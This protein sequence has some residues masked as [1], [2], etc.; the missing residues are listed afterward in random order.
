MTFFREHCL[1]VRF[2]G[3]GT[4]LHSCN[5][6]APS[7]N[8][9]SILPVNVTF[10]KTKA[11]WPTLKEIYSSLDFEKHPPPHTHTHFITSCIPTPQNLATMT[12]TY[13]GKNPTQFRFRCWTHCLIPY[14]WSLSDFIIV[15]VP[16]HR[17]SPPIKLS[18][19]DLLL[20]GQVLGVGLM[21]LYFNSYICEAPQPLTNYLK[22]NS[23]F[24][25]LTMT[26]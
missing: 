10:H 20:L 15:H 24:N 4:F 5:G 2:W 1:Q 14:A 23:G 26:I 9:C 18:Y 16:P 6:K 21:W 11:L 25:L 19:Y 3:S 8:H 12:M 7:N 17:R 13:F 22:S